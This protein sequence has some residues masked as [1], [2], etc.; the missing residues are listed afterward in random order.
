M[1]SSVCDESRK[2]T[3]VSGARCPREMTSS[4]T[5]SYKLSF[6][7]PSLHCV[8]NKIRCSVKLGHTHQSRPPRCRDETPLDAPFTTIVLHGRKCLS[9]DIYIYICSVHVYTILCMEYI[10]IYIYT[11]CGRIYVN[12][13][14]AKSRTEFLFYG[15]LTHKI[16]ERNEIFNV[17]QWDRF[18]MR[19]LIYIVLFN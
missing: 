7:C 19:G 9:K 18:Y 14:G 13:R 3:M 1:Q 15:K 12:L 11:L 10:Y 8:I 6:T 4:L 17:R 5:V 2:R 16:Q